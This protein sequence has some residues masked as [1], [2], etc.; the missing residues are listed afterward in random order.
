M[1]RVKD[2]LGYTIELPQAPQ[3]IVSLVPSQTELLHH[4]GLGERVVGITKFCVHPQ[5][6]WRKKIRVGGTKALDLEK[7]AELQPDL[8]IANVEE[9]EKEQIDELRPICPIW[10]SRVQD[11]ADAFLLIKDI[12]QLTDTQSAADK[13]GKELGQVREHFLATRTLHPAPRA[14]YLIWQEPYM[15]IGRDTFISS[16]MEECGIRNVFNSKLRYPA[17]TLQ[18][19]QKLAP[20]LVLLSSEPFPF[21]EK[22]RKLLQEQ[23]PNSR[24]MLVDGELFSWYGSRMLLA[25]PYFL[26]LL[27]NGMN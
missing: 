9:N 26:R 2:P 18:E 4:L 23:L 21:R 8:I 27:E 6:W 11:V 1:V 25:Y 13:L 17:T 3:R 7:V 22:H 12:G 5:S 20:E 15:G 24:V 14:A 16:M 19:L 10:T